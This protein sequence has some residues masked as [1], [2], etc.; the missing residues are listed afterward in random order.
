MSSWKG[1]GTQDPMD[2]LEISDG[3]MYRQIDPD[4]TVEGTTAS[5]SGSFSCF[6]AQLFKSAILPFPR[7]WQ[8]DKF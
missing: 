6:Y 8:T 1:R 2:D 5:I 4:K 7:K 3:G